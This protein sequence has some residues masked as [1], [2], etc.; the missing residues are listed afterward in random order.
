MDEK[1]GEAFRFTL[2]HPTVFAFAGLWDAWKDPVTG[3]WLQSYAI[4]TTQPNELIAPM[5]DRMPVILHEQDY[6]KWLDREQVEQPPLELLKPYEKDG[7]K[8]ALHFNGRYVLLA[9]LAG[10]VYGRAW[11]QERR[12]A[13]A[14][15]THALVDTVWSAWLR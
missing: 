2:Q 4:I 3:E 12:V 8:R 11:R 9:A 5:K 14:A 13:A 10:L 6:D 1:Q 7:N 15:L